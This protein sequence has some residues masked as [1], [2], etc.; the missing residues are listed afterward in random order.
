MDKI[1]ELRENVLTVLKKEQP[2]LA[3]I[4]EHNNYL[5][6]TIGIDRDAEVETS[7]GLRI[8]EI[9]DVYVLMDFTRKQE[10]IKDLHDYTVNLYNKFGEGVAKI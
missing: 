8:K 5:V 3:K 2:G 4:I 1:T 10:D 9:C 7:K 6:T